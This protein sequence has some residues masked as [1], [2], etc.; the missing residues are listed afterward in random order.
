MD[1]RGDYRICVFASPDPI[2]AGP[3]DLSV[4]IQ[5]AE[6]GQPL[7]NA[8][9]T[10][11]MTPSDGRGPIIRAVATNSA[12]TNKLLSAALLEVPKPGSWDVKVSCFVEHSPADVHFTLVAS[13]RSAEWTGMW[14]W[15]SWPAG[16]VI[17]F[18]VHRRLVSRR[19]S[20]SYH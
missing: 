5:D 13:G 11:S 3:I 6:T 9:V 14:A 18:G 2:S 15:F 1:R 4:L 8:R 12:A 17:L 16:M 7:T 20:A 19:K 10:V